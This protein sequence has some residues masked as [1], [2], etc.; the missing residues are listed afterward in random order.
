M[1]GANFY[2]YVLRK[3]KR[4]DKSTEVYEAMTDVIADI[5]TAIMADERQEE[6][7]VAGISTVGEYQI[8]LPS[9]F[10]HIIGNVSVTDTAGDDT[11]QPLRKISKQRYDEKYGDRSLTAVGNVHT[12]VPREY[13]I[14]AGQIY[15]GPVPDLTTYRYQI[16][17]STENTS[18]IVSGTAIVPF[19]S[20]IRNR[21]M[22]R[23]GVL[24]ELNEGLENF[25]EAAYHK[26]VYLDGLRKMKKMEDTNKAPTS[27]NVIYHGV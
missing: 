5:T 3:F 22:V 13:C 10:G 27:E 17:Y 25:E 26:A 11:Y 23:S 18:E 20:E 7:Y 4:T 8:A 19:T 2:S 14:Y 1:T 9:D 15:V 21:N 12:S 6:T 16:N 24:Y